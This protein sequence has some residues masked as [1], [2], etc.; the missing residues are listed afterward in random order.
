[1]RLISDMAFQ[2]STTQPEEELL[3]ETSEF[4]RK[5]KSTFTG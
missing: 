1:M 2:V 4:I 5:G 3:I